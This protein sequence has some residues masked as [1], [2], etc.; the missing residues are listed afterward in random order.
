MTDLKAETETETPD[1][2]SHRLTEAQWVEVV[3]LWERGEVRLDDLSARFGISAPALS[4]GLK[5][6][7]A[8]KGKRAG[9]TAKA[10]SEALKDAAVEEALSGA[11]L[12]AKRIAETRDQSYTWV[13]GIQKMTMQVLVEAKRDH[14]PFSVVAGDLKALRTAMNT[15]AMGRQERW[16]ILD[17]ENEVDD[18]TLPELVIRDLTE[19]EIEAL[20]QQDDEDAL[21]AGD[22][23]VEDIAAAMEVE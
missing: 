15:I 17:M 7:G 14:K 1:K 13:E 12:R 2:E 4:K 20:R 8:V 6:R 3:D 19:N 22:L 16:A 10:V 9:E 23:S 11:E 21:L 5:R 18:Q